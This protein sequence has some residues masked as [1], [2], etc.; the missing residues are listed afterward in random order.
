[1]QAGGPGCTDAQDP[2]AGEG[3]TRMYQKMT[4]YGGYRMLPRAGMMYYDALL[5]LPGPIR[6]TRV[7]RYD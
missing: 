2:D 6:G 4:V 5:T 3:M 1:M 7:T